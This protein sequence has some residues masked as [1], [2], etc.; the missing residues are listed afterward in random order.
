M[1]TA[2]GGHRIEVILNDTV[3]IMNANSDTTAQDDLV[4]GS[5]VNV[6]GLLDADGLHASWIVI[7]Q[8]DH[9]KGVV[10][11]TVTNGAFE[12]D[13][14]P[15]REND[16]T[17]IALSNQTL[18]L[19]GCDQQVG[20]SA[21]QPG[22]L[23]HIYGRMDPDGFKALA[24]F[25][26]PYEI[27]GS[28]T[29]VAEILDDVTQSAIGH[30]L[31]VAVNPDAAEPSNE[32]VFLPVGTPLKIQLDGEL[33]LPD[34]AAMVDCLIFPTVIIHMDPTIPEPLTVMTA[35]VLPQP[36]YA[37]VIAAV[38]LTN[39]IIPTDQGN[40]QVGQNAYFFDFRPGI[41]WYDGSQPGL[42]DIEPGDFLLLY[43]LETCDAEFRVTTVL[44]L[45][46]NA[47]VAE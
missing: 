18:I 20:P 38:D 42:M 40:I 26:R 32:T 30:N 35:T 7:G 21:I 5:V 27:V 3:V 19:F 29:A 23:A 22:M 47:T 25:L 2:T 10:T 28:I 16:P 8:I 33:A 15:N 1:L 14:Y 17:S 46:S 45:P 9:L 41:T 6:R 24:V 37:T 13:A 4:A 43:G 34:L 31:T 12:I 11:Q 39:R 36:R 44:I